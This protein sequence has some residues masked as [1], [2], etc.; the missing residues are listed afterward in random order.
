MAFVALMCSCSQKSNIITIKSTTA[1]VPASP[2][3][4]QIQGTVMDSK[5]RNFVL[6]ATAFR[7]SGDYADHVAVTV[8]PDGRLTYFPAPT[9]LSENSRPV[10]I[11]DGWWL[12]RQGLG[13]SS[14]FT[15]WTFNE[16]RAL[17]SVPSPEEIRQAIIPGAEVTSFITLPVTASEAAT[18]NP[19]DLLKYID[20]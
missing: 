11:G 19:A 16:Y 2:E 13:A 8:G 18:M 20:E 9:D 15:K 6:K 12:N 3:L 1:T 14:V 4:S 17:K 7:M 5:P 10:E